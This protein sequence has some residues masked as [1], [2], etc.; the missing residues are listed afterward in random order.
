M[1]SAS[2]GESGKT[3]RIDWPQLRTILKKERAGESDVC[4][5]YTLGRFH[6]YFKHDTNKRLASRNQLTHE[7]DLQKKCVSLIN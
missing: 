4:D 3:K 2:R 6:I 7:I 1:L 5:V